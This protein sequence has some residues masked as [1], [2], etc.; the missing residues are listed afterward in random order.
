M[1][2][3][4]VTMKRPSMALRH[5]VGVLLISWCA[6]NGSWQERRCLLKSF[7]IAENVLACERA[8]GG[9]IGKGR[10]HPVLDAH[11]IQ[12]PENCALDAARAVP[13]GQGLPLA[14]ADE[15]LLPHC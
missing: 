10:T 5:H 8:I 12:R 4:D 14:L 6:L 7:V 15:P 1:Q 13:K 11:R 9:C 2:V 3:T